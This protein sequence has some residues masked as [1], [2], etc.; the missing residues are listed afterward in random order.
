MH[1]AF[2]GILRRF[3]PRYIPAICIAA[4]LLLDLWGTNRFLG[5]AVDSVAQVLLSKPQQTCR[6]W[7]LLDLGRGNG[8]AMV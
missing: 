1:C 8:C 4:L 2:L 7:W 5:D 3:Q 6:V